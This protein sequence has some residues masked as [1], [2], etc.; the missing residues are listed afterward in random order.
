[1]MN[2]NTKSTPKYCRLH[3]KTKK[4][5][6]NFFK[7]VFVAM[8]L[9]ISGWHSEYS[10]FVAVSNHFVS[11]IDTISKQ[12]LNIFQ[13]NNHK[14]SLERRT[15]QIKIWCALK[16]YSNILNFCEYL[17][18]LTE[19]IGW[20]FVNLLSDALNTVNP[21]CFVSN[22]LNEMCSEDE[23]SSARTFWD[24]RI[25][26]NTVSVSHPLTF[27][28]FASFDSCSGFRFVFHFLVDCITGT[29][30]WAIVR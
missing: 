17:R 13:R 5:F 27:G 29:V 11:I 26:F 4:Y 12:N 3:S 24:L 6:L 21:L 1:M 19:Y 16:N 2:Q 23:M 9:V 30:R 7:I 15:F 18:H 10:F 14:I 8:N 28:R 25:V 20:N 22:Q